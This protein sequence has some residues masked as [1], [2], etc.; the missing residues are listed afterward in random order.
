MDFRINRSASITTLLCAGREASV[1]LTVSLPNSPRKGVGPR[2]AVPG[3]MEVVRF[4]HSRPGRGGKIGIVNHCAAYN[5]ARRG[6]GSTGRN[7]AGSA[8]AIRVFAWFGAA[9]RAGRHGQRHGRSS[10]F[11]VA[12]RCDDLCCPNGFGDKNGAVA[13]K[14]QRR[15]ARVAVRPCPFGAGK[16]RSVFVCG[17]RGQ[18]NRFA[19]GDGRI[20]RRNRDDSSRGRRQTGIAR[21]RTA[22]S[23]R[24]GDRLRAAATATAAAARQQNQR[25]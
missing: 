11:R 2:R 1:R 3:V 19:Y 10:H 22:R 4:D 24:R 7:N 8:G 13:A 15:D 5:R 17:Q 9:V 25:R 16:R 18:D 12:F 23:G 6:A 14:C 21:R 20:R